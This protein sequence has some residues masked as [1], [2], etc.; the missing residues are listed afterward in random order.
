[1]LDIDAPV[2]EKITTLGGLVLQRLD[3]VP[4][5]DDIIDWSGFQIKVLSAGRWGPKL[6]SIRRV[7]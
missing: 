1:R 4:R 7:A 5:R 2:D 6:L 3:R